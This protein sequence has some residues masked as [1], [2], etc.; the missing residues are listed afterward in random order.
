MLRENFC[1]LWLSSRFWK[2]EISGSPWHIWEIPGMMN[3]FSSMQNSKTSGQ[4]CSR[5]PQVA[6]V[7]RPDPRSWPGPAHGCPSDAAPFRLYGLT[8]PDILWGTDNRI[9][10]Y[11]VKKALFWRDFDRQAIAAIIQES[12]ENPHPPLPD[13]LW[14]MISERNFT[15]YYGI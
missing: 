8:A 6:D 4:Q 10:N 5:S 2:S 7:L 9:N 15:D 13:E 1:V 14:E 11:D 3:V 12:R